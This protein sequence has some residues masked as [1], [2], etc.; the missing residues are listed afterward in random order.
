MY[1]VR[2]DDV[3]YS[4][5]SVFI[6]SSKICFDFITNLGCS[7]LP[8]IDHEWN[9]SLYVN[10]TH[11]LATSKCLYFLWLQF[12]NTEVCSFGYLISTYSY[13]YM[14]LVFC[15][16]KIKLCKKRNHAFYKKAQLVTHLH[17]R[18]KSVLKRKLLSSFCCL[19]NEH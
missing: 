14:F 19:V 7:T 3:P 12:D 5:W 10:T 11:G 1:D 9:C 6:L 13:V 2:Q 17:D 4:H 15:C 16:R 8:P 18:S